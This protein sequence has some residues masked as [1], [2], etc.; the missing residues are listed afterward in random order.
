MAMAIQNVTVGS[1]RSASESHLKRVQRMKFPFFLHLWQGQLLEF[2]GDFQ[3]PI[4]AIL[5]D[6]GIPCIEPSNLNFAGKFP[7]N[8]T[9]R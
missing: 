1:K 9:S 2:T 4:Q 5:M 3:S 6:S 8:L 7:T